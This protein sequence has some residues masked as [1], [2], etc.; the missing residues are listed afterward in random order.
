MLAASASL[1]CGEPRPPDVVLVVIDTL[2]ADALGPYGGDVR[3]SPHLTALAAESVVFEDA[4]TVA[5]S[6]A[7]AMAA[8]MTGRLPGYHPHMIW[9]RR[10]SHGMRRFATDPRQ[11]PPR[12]A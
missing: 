2:R 12:P 5:P 3:A 9:T 7:P 4:V 6:T 1:A 8:L 10:I 11:A